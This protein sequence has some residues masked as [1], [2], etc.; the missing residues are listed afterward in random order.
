[1]A[2]VICTLQAGWAS[3]I[4]MTSISGVL[5]DLDNDDDDVIDKEMESS[6]FHV[7]FKS[8]SFILFSVIYIQGK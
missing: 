4:G 1:L 8:N 7:Y 6:S 2:A 3:R 5:T